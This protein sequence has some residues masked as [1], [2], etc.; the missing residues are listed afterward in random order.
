VEA[1]GAVLLVALGDLE[2]VVQGLLPERQLLVPQTLA[3]AEA[4][5]TPVLRALVV[6]V[7]SS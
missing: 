6:P 2:A 5:I 7:L 3:V 4:V 1:V